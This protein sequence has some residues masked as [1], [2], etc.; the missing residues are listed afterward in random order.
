MQNILTLLQLN[1][2]Q[3]FIKLREPV[4]RQEWIDFAPTTMNAF[5][6]SLFNKIG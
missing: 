2:K 5:Y 3:N 1:A 4:T 6:H